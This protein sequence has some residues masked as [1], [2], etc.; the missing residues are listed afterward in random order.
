MLTSDFGMSDHG[1]HGGITDAEVQLPLV[2]MSP[3]LNFDGKKYN[4]I[5]FILQ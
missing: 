4:F 1:S 5:I 3:K 2:F